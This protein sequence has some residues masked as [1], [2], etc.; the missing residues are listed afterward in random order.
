MPELYGWQHLTY[1]AIFFVVF[2][3]TI[4]LIHF[5]AKTE[6]QKLITIKVLAAVLLVCVIINRISVAIRFNDFWMFFPNSYCGATSLVLSIIVLLGKPNN[7]AY[8]FLWY[9]GLFGGI[10]TMFYPDFLG[11]DPSFLYLPTI[12]GLLHHSML[13]LLT[14]VMC[15]LKWFEPSLSNWKWFPIGICVYTL[16]GLFV[17]DIFNWDHAM[18]IGS[19][20]ISG[21]CLNWWFILI[22][23]TILLVGFLFLYEFIKRKIVIKKTLN[24]TKYFDD[25]KK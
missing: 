6:K 9:M 5:Y 11:Q 15:Q 19:A 8:H 10:A 22:V 23:G 24:L 1:L 16:Y 25:D 7:K 17:M 14:V 4:V 20:L 3:V 18:C 2:A 13:L 12:S 21:T